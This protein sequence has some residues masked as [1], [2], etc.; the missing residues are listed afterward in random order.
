MR[1]Y[2]IPNMNVYVCIY[3]HEYLNI[4]YLES[5]N[6]YYNFAFMSY[7]YTYYTVYAHVYAH[8]ASIALRLVL[9]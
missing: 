6:V 3:N 5:T 4:E 7:E 2:T 1:D 9:I 8:V